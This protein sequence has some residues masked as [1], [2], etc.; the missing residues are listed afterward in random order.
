MTANQL[1]SRSPIEAIL[2]GGGLRFGEWIAIS[3]MDAEPE[4]QDAA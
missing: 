2:T 4:G 3:M 1:H